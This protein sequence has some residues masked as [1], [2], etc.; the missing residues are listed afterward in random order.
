MKKNYKIIISGILVAFLLS[1]LIDNLVFSITDYLQK[2]NFIDI[3]FSILF[4]STHSFRNIILFTFL[5]FMFFY[6]TNQNL[7]RIVTVLIGIA[8]TGFLSFLIKIT[9]QRP[10]PFIDLGLQSKI[11]LFQF[12]DTSFPSFHAATAFFTL[13]FILQYNNKKLTISWI[14]LIILIGF[15]RIY[16]KVHFFS[17]FIA[18]AILGFSIGLLVIK[19]EKIY[20]K[21]YVVT[22]R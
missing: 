14:I 5:M 18:G 1:F 10:R 17:D 22:N 2:I 9:I 8:L 13:P 12:W 4:P 11:S 21:K 6:L 16:E 20:M 7:K 19:L 15:V 3:F